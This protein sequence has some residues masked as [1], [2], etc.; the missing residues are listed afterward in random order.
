MPEYGQASTS[1][2]GPCSPSSLCPAGFGSSGGSVAGQTVALTVYQQGQETGSLSAQTDEAGNFEFKGLALGQDY[3]Y[4]AS[5]NYQGAEYESTAITL[6]PDEP[7]NSL[8][9]EVY[10]STTSD[11]GIRIVNT[12]TVLV[13][14]ADRKLVVTEFFLIANETDRTYIGSSPVG[15]DGRQKTLS[16]SLLEGASDLQYG[17]GLMECCVLVDEEGLADS[18]P[19]LP[20]GK[21]VVFRYQV[22]YKPA[23]YD[24]DKVF[25]L[26][27]ER[28]DIVVQGDGVQ[29]SSDRLLQ[30]ETMA[31]D[32]RPFSHFTA[33]NLGRGEKV[34]ARFSNMPNLSGEGIGSVWAALLVAALAAGLAVAYPR[35]R[36]RHRLSPATARDQRGAATDSRKELLLEIA[37][38]DDAFD[39]G[40]IQE[41]DYR[42]QRQEK[43]RLLASLMQSRSTPR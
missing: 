25:Y 8:K 36:G 17:S 2:P 13:P 35:W 10:D 28:Y 7:T 1:S 15:P 29:A 24:F 9:L 21:E 30:Q 33:E 12:H 37:E 42:Q 3:G 5:V 27:A 22:K 41:E 4:V 31:I 18:M 43:K 38:L 6:V 40:S 14:D 16:F 32:G 20:G 34:T 19:V 23:R 39:R 11:E 26:P